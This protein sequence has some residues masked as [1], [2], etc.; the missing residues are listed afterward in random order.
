[1]SKQ[2]GETIRTL[3]RQ[4]NLTGEEL[5]RKAGLSQ[6]KISKIETGQYRNLQIK[7]LEIVLN[8][9]D[10]PKTIRQQIQLAMDHLQPDMIV[11][12]AYGIPYMSGYVE[13]E[14]K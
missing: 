8:I 9:L 12:K 1:M 4:R 11:H 13:I 14:K 10:A 5:A 7:E 2:I 6:S 3:R